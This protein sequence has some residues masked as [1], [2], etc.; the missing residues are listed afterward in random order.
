VDG[1]EQFNSINTVQLYKDMS[2]F[3]S[4]FLSFSLDN[5]ISFSPCFKMFCCFK[6]YRS[7]SVKEAESPDSHMDDQ[8][9][10][11]TATPFDQ[12]PTPDPAKLD[13]HYILGEIID[14]IEELYDD[15]RKSFPFIDLDILRT[16][17]IS[18]R[19]H[20]VAPEQHLRSF[21]KVYEKT[22]VYQ[23][24]FKQ[25]DE[26]TKA[27]INAFISEKSEDGILKQESGK[28]IFHL[29]PS[30]PAKRHFKDFIDEIFHHDDHH[31]QNGVTP[32]TESQTNS[33]T[34]KAAATRLPVIYE[35][36]AK[37]TI[38]EVYGDTQFN[39]WGQS[40]QNT[41]KYTFIPKK[42]LGLQNL[43]KYAKEHKL[44]VRVGGYRHS[45]SPMFS[46]NEEILISLL[47]LNE[48]TMIPNPLSIGPDY[49]DPQ[50]ELKVI[51]MA[52]GAA[53]TGETS[54]VRVGV[55]VTNEEFRRWA[56]END[57]WS[58]PMDVILVE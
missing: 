21:L 13:E 56:V 4:F 52:P 44:R 22:P 51:Q 47:N 20:H 38:M 23:L 53:T 57:T 29:P 31:Q 7:K 25:L 11:K 3:L 39:N 15:I 24:A 55:S 37:T 36:E 6:P 43:V 32:I 33:V 28:S 40:V 9:E 5:I 34:K 18:I 50:N 12:V 16:Q 46:Q 42:I 1:G 19:N 17:L 27:Q 49:I 14:H 35:D 54:L 58:L 26:T 48:V 45:W 10:A 30:P 41:P 2:L 8:M